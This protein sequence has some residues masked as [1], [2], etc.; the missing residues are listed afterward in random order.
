[1]SCP[2]TATAPVPTVESREVGTGAS[3]GES[4]PLPPY[5][6]DLDWPEGMAPETFYTP[7]DRGHEKRIA[8]R[9]AWWNEMRKKRK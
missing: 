4:T 1:M 8:E 9:I 2:L 6:H 5:S 3:A 7:T